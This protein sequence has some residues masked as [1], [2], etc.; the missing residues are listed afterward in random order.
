M[1]KAKYFKTE[2]LKT[3]CLL[4]PLKCSLSEDETGKC[5]GRKNINSVLYAVN[6]GEAAS[7][8]IDPIEKKPLYHFKPGSTILSTGPN[9]CNLS[10]SFC[11]N[12][13]ISQERIQTQEVSAE[14]LADAA[15]ESKSCGIAYTYTEP[16]IWWEFLMDVCPAVHERG[17]SNVLVTNGYIN[18]EPL[19]ELLPFIDAMNIDL[20]SFNPDFY[21]KLCGGELE[22]VKRNIAAS[23]EQT[24]VE[25]TNLLIPGENDS[26][27]EIRDLAEFISSVDRL[28]PVHFSAYSPKFKLRNPSTP[29][30]TV[31]R[32]LLIAGEYLDYVYAGNIVS[33]KGSCTVCPG[34]GN[35]LIRRNFYHT[36]VSGISGGKCL[37]CGR[38]A[39]IVF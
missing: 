7:V 34:C 28:I 18:E 26:D 10:C 17:F 5:F 11:Q 14:Q 19:A 20:K 27:D 9:G 38:K 15:V 25:I 39:D 32:A 3:R 35:V 22:T 1:I 23:H 29:L 6:Y 12:W 21:R 36:E 13:Q 24:H 37:R 33:E 30:G 16:L 4:C 8:A 2:G 31:E